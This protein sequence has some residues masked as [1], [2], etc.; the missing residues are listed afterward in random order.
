MTIGPIRPIPLGSVVKGKW[1]GRASREGGING[2][3]VCPVCV[4]LQSGLYSSECINVNPGSVGDSTTGGGG[5]GCGYP[6]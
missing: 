1:D 2:P 4:C 5:G 6:L 3:V